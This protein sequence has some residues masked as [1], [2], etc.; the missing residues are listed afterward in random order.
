MLEVNK[1]CAV[2]QIFIDDFSFTQEVHYW[3]RTYLNVDFVH[4]IFVTHYHGILRKRSR[5]I[6][7]YQAKNSTQFCSNYT[8]H[9][10]LLELRLL[11]K[12]ARHVFIIARQ[13]SSNK[14]NFGQ[15]LDNELICGSTGFE[16]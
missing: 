3:R 12:S 8:G 13:R 1:N 5:Q 9:G 4:F 10:E 11:E 7:C 16:Q 15:L 6:L 14:I 2:A